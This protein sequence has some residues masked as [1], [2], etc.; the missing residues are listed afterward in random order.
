V[1]FPRKIKEVNG[2]NN[3]ILYTDLDENQKLIANSYYKKFKKYY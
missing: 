1:K 3:Q 2:E